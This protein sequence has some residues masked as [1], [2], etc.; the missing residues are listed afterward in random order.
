MFH[1]KLDTQ[2]APGR[3]GGCATLAHKQQK[4]FLMGCKYPYHNPQIRIALEYGP[5]LPNK[6]PSLF[7]T[8]NEYCY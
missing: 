6:L 4:Q 7:N 3:R 2:Q 1:P 8:I 5:E